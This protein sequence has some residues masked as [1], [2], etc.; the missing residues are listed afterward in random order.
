MKCLLYR[1]IFTGIREKEED[2]EEKEEKKKL[3]K[4]KK[5]QRFQ[6]PR[7]FYGKI[8]TLLKMLDLS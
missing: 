1:R 4:K 6:K 7:K 3:R 8:K 2:E 5:K